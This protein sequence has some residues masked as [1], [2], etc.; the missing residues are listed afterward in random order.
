MTRSLR[1]IPL[2]LLLVLFGCSRDIPY[3]TEGFREMPECKAIYEQHAADQR[4]KYSPDSIDARCWKR[5]A[6]ERTAYDLLFAEFDDQGWLQN[7]SGRTGLAQDHLDLL[8]RKLNDLLAHHQDQGL[9]LVVFVHGWHH[10]AGANDTNVRGFRA[11]LG[12][13]VQD[14]HVLAGENKKG[15]RVVGLYVG[16][17]GESVTSPGL[18]YLTFWDRKN[19]AERVSQGS[20]RELFA[21]LDAFHDRNG[22]DK[23]SKGVRMITIGHSFGGLVA[24]EALSSEFLRDAARYRTT[25]PGGGERPKQLSRFGDLVIIVNPAFEGVRYEPVKA[26]AQRLPPL[27]ANQPPLA[28]IATST[29]DWATGLAFPAARFFNTLFETDPKEERIANRKTV[30]HND[31]YTTHRLSVCKPDDAD[32]WSACADDEFAH[33]AAFSLR[34]RPSG[35]YL[36]DGLT[37]ASTKE[38]APTGNP[39]WVVET[40]GDV[41]KDHDDIFNPYFISFVRQMYLSAIE[42]KVHPGGTEK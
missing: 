3:R 39:Y 29:A 15:R 41:M 10:N 36:C 40:T 20:V 6:E 32:C 23:G 30:G 4:V 26:A 18:N 33:M 31:R 42:D 37:L 34:D 13:L 8:F 21:K 22:D 17:R 5:E 9:M 24:F 19:T 16:W 38:W 1:F 11:L 35:A 27:E 14:V 28:I 12:S 7:T 2:V 25:G